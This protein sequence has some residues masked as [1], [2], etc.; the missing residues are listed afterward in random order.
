[1]TAPR[2]G[3]NRTMEETHPDERQ[4]WPALAERRL[5]EAE[6]AGDAARLEVLEDLADRLEAD[7]DLER[8]GQA[9]VDV[10][11]S[12]GGEARSAGR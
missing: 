10:K 11:A 9:A 6:E 8:P 12:E 1:M 3:F 5:N 2:V 4:D 7:L